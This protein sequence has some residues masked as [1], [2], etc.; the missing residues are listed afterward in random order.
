MQQMGMTSSFYD[1]PPA[2]PQESIAGSNDYFT[3]NDLNRALTA[4]WQGQVTSISWR[5]YLLDK[6]TGVKPG[7]QYLIPAGVGDGVVSH[8]NGFF[9]VPSGWVDND[10][11]IVTFQRGGKTYAYAISFFTQFVGTKYADIPL[12][13]DVSSMV[14]QYFSGRYP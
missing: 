12:G 7:L 10:A 6:M 9:V 3:A 5:D 11:G 13:Q 4:F 2:Y 8:K 1:H 14:W